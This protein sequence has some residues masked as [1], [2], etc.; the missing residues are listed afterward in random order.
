M[1]AKVVIVIDDELKHTGVQL[2][3]VQSVVRNS[4][5]LTVAYVTTPIRS[6][7][8]MKEFFAEYGT[9]MSDYLFDE[10]DKERQLRIHYKK[11]AEASLEVSNRAKV[12]N[13]LLRNRV[14]DFERQL[15]Q[16]LEQA[17]SN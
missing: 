11:R 2:R 9:G 4:N 16:E 1:A 17:K 12:D 8:D 15:K 3:E 7:S 10:L 6:W 14:K 5:M 13:E